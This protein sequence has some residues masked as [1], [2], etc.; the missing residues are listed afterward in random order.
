MSINQ[1]RASD[2]G[3]NRLERSQE[4]SLETT[5]RYL[6]KREKGEK[7]SWT[8]NLTCTKFPELS[9]VVTNGQTWKSYTRNVMN[10]FT[11]ETN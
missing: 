4:R 9:E 10:L 5:T 7:H 3:G 11:E 6:P 1:G 8:S 2:M